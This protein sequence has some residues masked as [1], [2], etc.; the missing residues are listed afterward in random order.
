MLNGRLIFFVTLN[1]R[2]IVLKKV[3]QSPSDYPSNHSF[4]SIH[5]F[6]TFARY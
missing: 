1:I 2:K 5:V 4:I 3:F 6:P